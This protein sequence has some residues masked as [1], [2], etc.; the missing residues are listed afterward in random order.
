MP[1]QWLNQSSEMSGRLGA[2]LASAYTA[3]AQPAHVRRLRQILLVLFILWALLALAKLVWALLP[4]AE[5][6]DEGSSSVINAVSSSPVGVRAEPVDL[7]R[8]VGWHLFG[9][10]SAPDQVSPEPETA[11]QPNAREGIED[12]ARETRL[13]LKLRGIVASTEDG[14]GYAI[15]EHKNKQAV[16]AVEDK[17]PVSGQVVLAKVMP[18]QIVLDNGGTYELLVLFDESG[19]GAMAT[20]TP[21]KPEPAQTEPRVDHRD[22]AQT[23][24]LALSYR[25][26]LYQNPQSLV[27]VV[28]VSAV[29][30]GGVL[31]GYRVQPGKDREQFELLGFKPGDLVTAVNGVSLDNPANTMILYNTMRTAGEAVF[32][33]KR[34]GQPLTLSVN[35]DSGAAQ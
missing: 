33:L 22:D 21:A 35:L 28:N 34:E 29:R 10:A 19:L 27:E 26:R 11:A 7:D 16:Y 9:Q 30:E 4:V 32:E 6:F 3:W 23:T 25:E 18:Q 12:G 8:M 31:S 2:A 1:A 17:L 24:D 20:S 15:I 5:P 14:L 13:Q